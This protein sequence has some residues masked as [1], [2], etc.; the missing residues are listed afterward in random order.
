MAPL[1][2]LP[3]EVTGTKQNR[4]ITITEFRTLFD[5]LLEICSINNIS[6]LLPR[7]VFA[8]SEKHSKLTP[9]I[10]ATCTH[11]QAT[12]F[13]RIAV[14]ENAPHLTFYLLKNQTISVLYLDK[15]SIVRLERSYPD[16]T[17]LHAD[18]HYHMAHLLQPWA[19]PTSP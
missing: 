1:L 12:H 5:K 3:K 6:P 17:T 10:L 18:R 8:V 13:F 7:E 14:Q 11:T 19:I 2:S 4:M 15:E 9:E 16:I